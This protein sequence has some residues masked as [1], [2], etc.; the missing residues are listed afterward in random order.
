MMPET[1]MVGR[2]RR[3]A[4]LTKSYFRSRT[5][6]LSLDRPYS[7]SREVHDFCAPIPLAA[8]KG[9]WQILLLTFE[10]SPKVWPLL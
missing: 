5:C 1:E 8:N 6:P 2:A 9:C 10:S 3:E 4:C 7:P